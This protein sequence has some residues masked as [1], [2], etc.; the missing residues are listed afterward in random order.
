MKKYAAV[1]LAAGKG[2]RMNEGKES[3]IPK[4]MYEIAGKPII[5]WSVKLTKDAGIDKIVLVVGYKKELIEDYFGCRLTEKNLSR[6]G[7]RAKADPACENIEFAVQEPQLGTGHAAASAR[8]VLEGKAES[9]I[10]F[11]GDNPLY[12]PATVQKLITLYENPPSGG[13]PTIAMMTVVFDNPEFWV[14]GRIIKDD[15]GHV[16]DIIEQKDCT[17]EQLKITEC[18]PG[19]YIFDAKWFWANVDKLETNNAQGEYY[20]TDMVRIAAQQGKKVVSM[21]VSEIGEALGINN[22]E[23]Q[24]KAEEIILR[25]QND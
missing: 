14:F 25:R 10:V 6:L 19:F 24:K 3:S 12:Q 20:L 9:I 7:S 11:Y 21:P 1:I 23:Q 22:P 2:T 8:S 5:A 4:V 15:N 13:K 17:L 18:N 16:I